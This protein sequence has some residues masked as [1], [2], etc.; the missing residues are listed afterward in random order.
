MYQILLWA[1]R[2][3]FWCFAILQNGISSLKILFT[4]SSLHY[5]KEMAFSNKKRHHLLAAKKSNEIWMVETLVGRKDKCQTIIK[6]EGKGRPWV[7]PEKSLTDQCRSTQCIELSSFCLL[8]PTEKIV[9]FGPLFKI[10]I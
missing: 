10:I 3:Q 2:D 8:S 1:I 4:L 7:V 9:L 6:R 5:W